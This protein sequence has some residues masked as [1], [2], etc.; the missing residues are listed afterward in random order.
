MSKKENNKKEEMKHIEEKLEEAIKEKKECLSDLE[1]LKKDLEEE[2]KKSE[3]YYDQ[4]LRLKAEFENY[5]KRVEKEKVELLNWAKYDFIQK[6][7]PLYDMM[8][9]AKSH[10]NDANSGDDIKKGLEMIF[11]EFEKVFKSEGLVEIDVLNKKYD[12]MNCEIVS[13]VEGSEDNDDM[14]VEIIQPGYAIDGKILRAAKVK[15]AKKRNITTKNEA[16]DTKNE[17]EKDSL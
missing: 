4:L 15:V 2:K 6:I 3:Q 7:L 1:L 14:V 10:I 12:P 5:R 9:M 17:N 13:I 8:R 16:D 11:S